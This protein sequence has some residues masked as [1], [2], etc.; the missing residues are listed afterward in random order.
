MSDRMSLL[1]PYDRPAS[2]PDVSPKNL[3][4]GEWSY[5]FR[6]QVLNCFWAWR[7]GMK[8]FSKVANQCHFVPFTENDS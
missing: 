2:S 8:T 7:S 4:D 6:D 3:A 1:A 5:P